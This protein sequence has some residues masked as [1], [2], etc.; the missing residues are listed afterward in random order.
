VAGIAFMVVAFLVGARALSDNSFLT[1]LATGRLILG[2]H[3]PHTDPY[4]FTAHGSPWVAQS[5]IPAILYATA[6]KIAGATAIRLLCGALTAA[7][8]A[9]VWRL[10][11]D[12]KTLVPRVLIAGFTL[13]VGAGLWASRP[14]MFGLIFLAV[15]LVILREDRRPFWLLPLFWLCVNCHGSWPLGLVLLAVWFVGSR[16]DHLPTTHTVRCIAWSVG[17]AVLGAVGPLGLSALTFPIDLVRRTK[18]LANVVEWQA[19]KFVATDQRA[20]LVAAVIA[21]VCVARRPSYRNGLLT[22]AFVA[23]AL[24]GARNIVV[25]SVVLVPVLADGLSD[26]GSLAGERRSPTLR[27]AA[28]GLVAIAVLAGVSSLRQPSWDFSAYPVRATAYLQ[29]HDLIGPG[30]R[31]IARDIVGNYWEYRFGTNANVFFDDRFDM[32]SNE[33]NRE[34]DIL[35]NVKPGWREV[36][37]RWHPDAILWKRSSPLTDLLKASNDWRVAYHDRDWVVFVPKR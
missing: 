11:R 27:L 20:F 26:L 23:C 37:T 4:S 32:Y 2:G 12:A 5:W 1:H 31:V 7:L 15:T 10:T 18:V 16:A 8:M 36:I 34:H 28:A 25:A 30:H 21:I 6:E 33:M 14:Y 13:V 29:Q 17:G 9:L 19:P 24:L 35:L 22:A 3:F